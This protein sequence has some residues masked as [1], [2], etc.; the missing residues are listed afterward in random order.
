M[1]GRIPKRA[2]K[3]AAALLAATA[4]VAVAAGTA[5]AALIY[6]NIPKPLPA[7]MESES[8]QLG[9]ASEFGGEV[10]FAG[11]ARKKPSVTVVMSSWFCEYG[12]HHL[13]S[14]AY[15]GGATCA[16]T[17]GATF[18][19]PITLEIYKAENNE[20]EGPPIATTK[21]T[22]EIPYRPTE[23]K[24]C[25]ET[26]EGKGYGKECFLAKTHE[27]TF[28]PEVT[29]P[30]KAI[31]A[32]AFNTQGYGSEPTGVEGPY[33]GL[34]VALTAPPSSAAEGVN[35]LLED[36][37]ITSASAR[38]YCGSSTTPGTFGLSGSAGEPFCW[39]GRQPAF[40]VVASLR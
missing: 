5:S 19:Q 29:L 24:K 12:I 35:P 18:Q 27:I 40:K 9:E 17:P 21:L 28:H 1:I 3:L 20:P 11:T 30:A 22:F 37:F 7:M 32:V 25:P 13:E 34:N 38:E 10:Q 16:S 39:E 14:G 31:I 26:E 6:N 2:A 4:V 15:G 33:N 8:F 36:A 23:S